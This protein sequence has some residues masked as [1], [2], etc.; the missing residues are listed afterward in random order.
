VDHVRQYLTHRTARSNAVFQ[1][2]LAGDTTPEAMVL[3]I[4]QDTPPAMYGLAARSV[5]AMLI[6]H[7]EEGR[8]E[9]RDGHWSAVA[10]SPSGGAV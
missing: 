2:V 5:L 6:L 1:R 7:R 9:E 10:G 3:R 8:V 4:Y